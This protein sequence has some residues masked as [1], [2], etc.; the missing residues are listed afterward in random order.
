MQAQSKVGENAAASLGRCSS[1]KTRH[2]QPFIIIISNNVFFVLDRR[3][4]NARAV[5]TQSCREFS[6]A[7]TPRYM[8]EGAECVGQWDL[9]AACFVVVVLTPIGTCH[10]IEPSA[11]P[12]YIRYG[13]SLRSN[14]SANLGL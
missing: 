5:P 1:F 2:T 14:H 13:H 9:L 7:T 12:I 4:T 6:T 8:N 11:S 3:S 10:R